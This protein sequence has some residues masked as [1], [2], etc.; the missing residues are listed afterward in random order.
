MEFARVERDGH[1]LVVTIDRPRVLN[2]LHR[3]ATDELDEVWTRFEAD[4]DLRVAILTGAG[5]RA[6]SAGYDMRDPAPAGGKRGA[7]SRMS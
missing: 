3:A 1:L 4:P 7:G 5:D 6:F 2:A